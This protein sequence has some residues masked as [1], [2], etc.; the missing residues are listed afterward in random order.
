MSFE[1][2]AV[3]GIGW[4]TAYRMLFTKSGLR[5]GQTMLVQGSSGGVTTALIQLGS[6]AGMRVWCTGRSPAKR[7]LGR[8]LG[9]E[10]AFEASAELPE[11]V[12]AVFDTSGEV[13]WT[14]TMASVKTG[15]TIVTCGG[16]SGRGISIDVTNLFVQQIDIRGSYLGKLEEFRDLISFVSLKDIK[17]HVGLM[18]PLEE[19]AEGLRKML[20]GETEGKIVV[21]V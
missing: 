13:T 20:G 6:A 3:L 17:P 4:L 14:H 21:T 5:A 12:D 8:H 16:H 2:A 1:T 7:E 19:A 18:I 9:A 11:K 15:G 10:K